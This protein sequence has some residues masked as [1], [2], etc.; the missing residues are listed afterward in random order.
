MQLLDLTIFVAV[1]EEGTVTGAARRLRMTQPGVTKHIQSLEAELTRPLF[2]RVRR[3]L[4]LTEFGH[5]FLRRAQKVLRDV[6]RLKD[7]AEQQL[8]PAGVL[9]LGLT[10]AATQGI[11]PPKLKEFRDAY[12]EV[13]F[14]MVVSDSEHIEEGVLRGRYDLGIIAAADVPH[15]GLRQRVIDHDRIDAIVGLGHPLARRKRVD[16]AELARFPIM[17][18]PRG[19]RTRSI[20]DAAFRERGIV[21]VEIIE[22]HY[23]SAAVRLVEAGLGAALLSRF[24]IENELPKGRTAHL[25]IAG[26]PFGR[27]IC[28]VRKRDERISEAAHRFY[29]L[30]LGKAWV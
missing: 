2:D 27:T 20:V 12:P 30:L 23:N 3:R 29:K 16:L 24:F 19:S 5:R 11:I 8:L 26:D 14:E 21:P 10:D 15:G 17:V 22:V 25:R 13:R 1:V 4:V 7:V 9:R 6:D 28:V 18:Y